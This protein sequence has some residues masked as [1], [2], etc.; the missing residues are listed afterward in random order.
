MRVVEVAIMKERK[1]KEFNKKNRKEIPF[2]IL[3]TFGKTARREEGKKEL[4][5]KQG[6]YRVRR[7]ADG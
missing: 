1:K 7:K 6:L 4:S 5:R 2:L 3:S